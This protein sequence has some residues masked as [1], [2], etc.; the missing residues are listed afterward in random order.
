MKEQWKD[1]EGHEGK[2]AV[3]NKGTVMSFVQDGKG[4]VLKGKK[5]SYGYLQVRISGKNSLM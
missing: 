4:K 1:I 2:Y 5:D 3:S